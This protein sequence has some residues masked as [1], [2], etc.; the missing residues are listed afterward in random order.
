VYRSTRGPMRWASTFAVE[1]EGT[2]SRVASSGTVQFQ[3]LLRVLQPLLAG[4][5]QSGEEKELERLKAILEGGKA[6]KP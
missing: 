6:E 4:E 5:V 2:G 1:P 3:G